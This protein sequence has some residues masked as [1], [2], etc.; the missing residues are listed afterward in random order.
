MQERIHLENAKKQ[1]FEQSYTCVCCKDTQTYTSLERG[2]KPLVAWYAH[3]IDLQGF[4]VADK[5][6]G[7]G[8]AFLYALLN[9]REIYAHVLSVSALEVLTRYGIQAE[10][11]TL[12]DHIQNRAGDGICPFENAVLHIQDR[13]EAYIAIRKRMDVMHITIDER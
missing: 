3:G 7:K 13:H 12:V 10:Y 2:I 5:V 6:V 8:A 11:G 1:L 4:S 9:V